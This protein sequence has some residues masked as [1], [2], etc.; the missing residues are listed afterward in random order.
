MQYYYFVASLPRLELGA[1]PHITEE[2]FREQCEAHLDAADAGA[3]QALLD[4]AM[5]LPEA[6]PHPFVREW[7]NRETQ[8]R[9]ALSRER[10]S[11]AHADAAPWKRDHEGFQPD[12]ESAAAH[13]FG[14]PDPLQRERSLDAFRWRVIEE[15][16]GTDEFSGDAVLAY[17]LK[18]R[19]A[20]RWA[21]ISPEQGKQRADAILENE[22]SRE[23][24]GRTGTAARRE[25][26]GGD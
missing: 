26:K 1:P 10:A 4:D 14:L 22:T 7:T 11:R 24:T 8:L 21:A 5:A 9:N 13:A 18:L 6:S 12:I 19:I 20:L 2:V 25:E 3:S 17:A 16:Q 15:L 23:Q